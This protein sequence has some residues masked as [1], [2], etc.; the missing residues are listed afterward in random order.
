M[1]VGVASVIAESDVLHLNLR[2]SV[3]ALIFLI[4]S[5]T[6]RNGARTR[7]MEESQRKCARDRISN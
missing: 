6:Q 7:T 3:P 1:V 5:R 4:R 2:I